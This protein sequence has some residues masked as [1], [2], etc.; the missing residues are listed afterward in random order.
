MTREE[1]TNRGVALT[2]T[3]PF[4]R[5]VSL[6]GS[7]A[8]GRATKTS[9]IDFF[10]QIEDGHIWLSRALITLFVQLAG[11]RRTDTQIANRIC[12]NWFAT[13]DAPAKQPGRVY[14]I[15]WEEEKRPAIKSFFESLLAVFPLKYLENFAKTIQINRIER[16]RRTHLPSSA[17]R[18]S[19]RELGFHPPKEVK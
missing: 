10:V 13:Y 8:E 15:L 3:V 17:V 11:I 14:K 16:D 2:S 7:E 4:T 9:D 19:D 12:L 1:I 6:T 18:Y 5:M